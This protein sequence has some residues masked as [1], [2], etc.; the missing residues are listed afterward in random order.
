MSGKPSEKGVEE[1]RLCLK[2]LRI[3]GTEITDL[4]AKVARLKDAEDAY[5]RVYN[6][7]LELLKQMDTDNLGNAGWQGRLIWLLGEL[8]RQALTESVRLTEPSP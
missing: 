6:T 3:L 5:G 1:L 4:R 8:D 2:S 7:T